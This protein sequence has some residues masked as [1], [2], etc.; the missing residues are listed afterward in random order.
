MKK[1]IFVEYFEWLNFVKFKSGSIKNYIENNFK[2]NSNIYN[3]DFKFSKKT[4]STKSNYYPL[5]LTKNGVK[6]E[7]CIIFV[8]LDCKSI[9]SSGAEIDVELI[10]KYF[11][12]DN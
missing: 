6:V 8:N 4:K 10:R 5:K 2:N 3:F 7:N 12:G 1:H 11:V 9:I